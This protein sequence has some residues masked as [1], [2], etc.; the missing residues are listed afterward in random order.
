MHYGQWLFGVVMLVIIVVVSWVALS[1]VGLDRLGEPIPDY[2]GRRLA[3][4]PTRLP[5]GLEYYD[6]KIGDGDSPS[7]DRAT[8]RVHYT[9]WL[10]DGTKFDSSRDR[11]EPAEFR[12]DGVIE[13]WR[14]GLKS[15]K[16]G[17]QRK[18]IVPYQL[19]YGVAGSGQKI[20]P[21]AMLVFDVEL[22]AVEN[23]TG[24]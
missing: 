18:L 6:F 3:G 4:L 22:L 20:P 8:V 15:M 12:L 19:G 13:G 21:R 1:Q 9:G 11:G 7:S 14:E 10:V 24:P 16:V 5:G 2:P 23:P 17:G